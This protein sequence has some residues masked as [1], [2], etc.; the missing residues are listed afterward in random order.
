MQS[1]PNS[2]V[3]TMLV[4]LGWSGVISIMSNQAL[5][6]VVTESTKAAIIIIIIIIL[7]NKSKLT[8]K[9]FENDKVDYYFGTER[10]VDQQLQQ[11]KQTHNKANA[12][13]Q[14]AGDIASAHR[15]AAMIFQ[16]RINTI[17]AVEHHEGAG[18]CRESKK[19]ATGKVDMPPINATA[20][21]VFML[22]DMVQMAF[23]VRRLKWYWFISRRMYKDHVGVRRCCEKMTPIETIPE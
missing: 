10:S 19:I 22:E 1:T 4:I 7:M 2:F 20:I 3:T 23:G 15:A 9:D 12:L 8:M 17:I 5:I 16:P 21:S 11:K 18:C 6:G 13:R 14:W